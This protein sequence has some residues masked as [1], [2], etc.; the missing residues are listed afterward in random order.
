MKQ[1]GTVSGV[2]WA[3]GCC[4]AHR[5]CFR[6][7]RDKSRTSVARSHLALELLGKGGLKLATGGMH[8]PAYVRATLEL[9]RSPPSKADRDVPRCLASLSKGHGTAIG[10]RVGNVRCLSKSLDRAPPSVALSC[11][12]HALG[13]YR[14]R[15]LNNSITAS[16]TPPLAQL[17]SNC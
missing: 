13:A 7:P 2:G 10:S 4:P 9:R 8:L 15:S 17:P 1:D 6:A 11:G 5:H 14:Q 12:I 16:A 3:L